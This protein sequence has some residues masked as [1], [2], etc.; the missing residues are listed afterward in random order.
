MRYYNFNGLYKKLRPLLKHKV[1]IYR[2]ETT[3]D[4]ETGIS[5]EEYKPF[6]LDVEAYI[7]QDIRAP[8]LAINND[9][10]LK[11]SAFYNLHVPYFIKLRTG[12]WVIGHGV[13]GE[14]I[15]HGF[16]GEVRYGTALNRALIN[17]DDVKEQNP[18]FIDP[19]SS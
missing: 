6:A 16:L 3:S 7:T 18:T 15:A 17:K 10:T 8:Y 11:V 14:E 1:D 12:D 13:E 5:S 19:F 4:S 9:D 2:A